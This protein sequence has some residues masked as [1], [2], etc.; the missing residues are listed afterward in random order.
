MNATHGQNCYANRDGYMCCSERLELIMRKSFRKLRR[1][2]GFHGCSVQLI[3]NQIQKDAEAT[4]GVPFESVVG[5]DDFAIRAH[6]VGELTCKIEQDGRFVAA[7]AT[8]TPEIFLSKA[9]RNIAYEAK[10]RVTPAQNISEA[11]LLETERNI[12]AIADLLQG[13]DQRTTILIPE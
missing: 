11:E 12:Q 13:V 7:Y 8:A 9:S 6:F 5:I 1:R 2:L 3:A 4:F 10:P